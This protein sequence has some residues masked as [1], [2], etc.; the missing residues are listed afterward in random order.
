MA[1]ESE[2]AI[3]SYLSVTVTFFSS[4]SYIHLSFFLPHLAQG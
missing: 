4:V 3:W 1:A 2:T